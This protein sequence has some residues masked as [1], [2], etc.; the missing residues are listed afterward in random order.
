M[1][2][3]LGD[4]DLPAGLTHQ[5]RP[6]ALRVRAARAQIQAFACEATTRKL[7]AAAAEAIG[8]SHALLLELRQGREGAT[9]QAA[10]ILERLRDQRAARGNTWDGDP[11]DVGALSGPGGGG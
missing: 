2:P 7:L 9:R 8:H 3:T 10:E 6:A 11:D 4:G 5:E 1:S